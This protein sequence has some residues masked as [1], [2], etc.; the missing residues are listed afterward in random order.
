[1]PAINQ[2]SRGDIAILFTRT[3][4]TIQADLMFS[5]H[6]R[7]DKYGVTSKPVIAASDRSIYGGAGENRWG[8]YFSV[9]VDPVDGKLFWGYGMT[10]RSDGRWSTFVSTFKVSSAGDNALPYAPLTAAPLAGQGTA[11]STDLSLLGAAD[12]RNFNVLSSPV[13]SVGQVSSLA[14]TYRAAVNSLTSDYV[15]VEFQ[16]NAPTGATTFV[17]LWNYV[18]KSYGPAFTQPSGSGVVRLAYSDAD[19][20]KYISATGEIR[21]LVRVVLPVRGGMPAEFTLSIDQL[22]A[23][24]GSK[25]D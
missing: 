3:S 1:M 13:K 4:P 2:N 23:M 21:A 12:G 11:K 15:A 19:A 5:S 25:L 7:S 20:A 9:A 18:T 17:Y 24:A 14:T 16:A 10:S 6:K 22:R 8:D